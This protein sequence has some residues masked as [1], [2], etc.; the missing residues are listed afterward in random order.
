MSVGRSSNL[1]DGNYIIVEADESDGSF[2]HLQPDIAVITNID[3]DHLDFYESNQEK[4]NQSFVS[5]AENLPFY[6]HIFLNIDDKNIYKISRNIHRKQITYG[7][8]GKG[9][10]Q[11]SDVSLKNGS[12]KFKLTDNL[13]KKCHKFFT[14]LNGKHNFTMLLLL[15]V[16]L[17]KKIFQSKIFLKGLDEFKGVGRRFEVSKSYYL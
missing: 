10:F 3:N 6:G 4:L 15:F 8:S 2:L 7:F 13:N 16:L 14:N 11:I 17:L 1:G 9:R 5:F 12:Q